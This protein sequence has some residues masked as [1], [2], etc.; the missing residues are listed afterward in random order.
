MLVAVADVSET[1]PA[2]IFKVQ[3]SKI[4]KKW[5][6][7]TLNIERASSTETQVFIPVGTES[8]TRTLELPLS[9]IL[10][11]FSPVKIVQIDSM[12]EAEP[13]Q[14]LQRKQPDSVDEFC[15][16]LVT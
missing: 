5:N 3:K 9:N 15:V 13:H 6:S 16:C 2:S 12:L 1:L 11:F 8:H 7:F 10:I 14:L 4:H